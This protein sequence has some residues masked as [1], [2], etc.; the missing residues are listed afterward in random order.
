[1][2]RLIASLTLA[3][4]FFA[5]SAW[6]T[7]YY[8]SNAGSDSN[9]GLTP[10]TAFANHPCNLYHAPSV[11]LAAGDTV[12]MR[13]GDT[14]YQQYIQGAPAGTA[15][16]PI[17]TISLPTFY[18]VS[19]SDPL[20]H[21]SGAHVPSAVAW[22]QVGSTTV[23]TTSLSSAPAQV[24]YN[25]ALLTQGNN[26]TPNVGQWYWAGNVLYVNV[27]GNPAGGVCEIPYVSTVVNGPGNYHQF[28][29]VHFRVDNGGGLITASSL[30]S[31]KF[32]ACEFAF[33]SPTNYFVNLSNCT[34]VCEVAGCKCL[35][36]LAGTGQV[37]VINVYGTPSARV[38]GNTSSGCCGGVVI[39][40]SN[41][42]EVA[43]NTFTG[44][45]GTAS[46]SLAGVELFNSNY[47]GVHGNNLQG[48]T[49]GS[50]P[51]NA[52]G[53]GVFLMGTSACNR[54][55]GNW[56]Q[57]NQEGIEHNCTGSDENVIAY[58]VV[59]GSTVN[60]IDV[61]GTSG[62]FA[63]CYNNTIDHCPAQTAGHALDIQLGG[64]GPGFSTTSSSCGRPP[65]AT[66]WWFPT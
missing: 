32:H 24:V 30:A 33:A 61:I 59:V 10:A 52:S 54:I 16:A 45:G 22:T 65:T 6:A 34:G 18:A 17:R 43:D 7:I 62:G 44:G 31:V 39:S 20:P 46:A 64:A 29:S 27:S 48:F 9:N 23:Y 57:G 42:C 5:D 13:R 38:C 15:A 50:Y 28:E 40:G 60:G 1:M 51:T 12:I 8:V 3:L 14:W 35:Y 11:T 55:V 58:N 56:C 47:C 63:Y 21:I 25:N 41:Y 53:T 37:P 26:T 49:A 4:V 66:V 2:K 36:P 19:A